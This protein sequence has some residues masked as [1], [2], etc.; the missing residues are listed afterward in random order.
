MWPPQWLT[1]QPT[2]ACCH[3]AS[4]PGRGRAGRQAVHRRAASHVQAVFPLCPATEPSIAPS[5]A[6]TPNPTRLWDTAALVASLASLPCPPA[7]V[8]LWL[9]R[10]THE[11]ALPQVLGSLPVVLSLGGWED[12]C[13]QGRERR[14][15]SAGQALVVLFWLGRSA[16][17]CC[18]WPAACKA[19]NAAHPTR[20]CTTVCSLQP[21]YDCLK[22]TLHSTG[23]AFAVA[24]KLSNPGPV[25]PSCRRRCALGCS[26]IACTVWAARSTI[27]STGCWRRH[28]CTSW[29]CWWWQVGWLAG[30]S[31]S[32][33]V[34]CG[35]VVG[36][37]FLFV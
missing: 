23:L 6:G 29:H 4:S 12:A 22:G 32:V 7:N 8:G 1:F 36:I 5:A 15:L 2:R 34:K 18:Q 10:W 35:S 14:Q 30:F 33:H 20:G 11:L 28:L 16:W 24:A 13:L 21:G 19:M 25:P 31:L 37:F 9:D 27:C 17:S 3:S 26:C